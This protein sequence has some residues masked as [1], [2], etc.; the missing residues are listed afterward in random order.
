MKSSLVPGDA[1][2]RLP[3]H[4][5]QDTKQRA[6]LQTTASSID[7]AGMLQHRMISRV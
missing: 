4:S 3:V 2:V 1:D 5:A 6:M 7:Y